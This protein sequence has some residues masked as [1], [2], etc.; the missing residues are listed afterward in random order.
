MSAT[1]DKIHE[2]PLVNSFETF[3]PDFAKCHVNV[4]IQALIIW[5]T[6]SV[7]LKK[8]DYKLS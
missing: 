1:E 5:D 3:I 6:P 4:K 2:S 7:D 8:N